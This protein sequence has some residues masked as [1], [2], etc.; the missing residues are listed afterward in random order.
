MKHFFDSLLYLRLVPSGHISAADVGSGAG[1]PGLPVALVRPDID[2]ALIEPSRKKTAFLRHM[3]RTLGT[4]NVV[5]LESRAEELRD[6]RF[7]IV[8][9]RALFT[10]A[11][12]V[13]RAGHLLE[14]GGSFILSKGPKIDAELA[15]L[16][17]GFEA[18]AVPAVVPT[19]ALLRHLI[20][21]QLHAGTVAPPS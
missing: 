12:F 3:S 7:D 18:R 8:M 20:A 16:P 1:F 15:A 9:T 10:V 5:V 4:G 21:V 17:E 13:K 6:R 14:K 19:S 2:V 11:E